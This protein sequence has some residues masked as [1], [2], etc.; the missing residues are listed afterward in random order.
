MA[1]P[2]GSDGKKSACNAG[3]PSSISGSGRY[4]LEKGMATHSSILAWGIPWKEEPGGL[5]SM[6]LQRIRHNWATKHNTAHTF[7]ART[8]Y[9]KRYGIIFPSLI[10]ILSE[11]KSYIL[12]FWNFLAQR[13]YLINTDWIYDWI[14]ILSLSTLESNSCWGIRA[15]LTWIICWNNSLHLE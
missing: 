10:E 1:F 6:V 3:D 15:T 13:S 5:Q 14:A 2:G 7:M 9:S 12:V 4:R 11:H 8:W